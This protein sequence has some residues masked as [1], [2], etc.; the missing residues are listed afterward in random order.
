[1]TTAA[2]T[3]T[4]GSAGSSAQSTAA[5][6]TATSQQQ[7]AANMNTF[8]ELLTAQLQNQDPL[9]PMDT[10]QFTN[11]LV[12]FAQV[13]QQIDI[14]QNL[15]T[16]MGS[17]NS[18]ALAS[19]ANYIGTGVTAV[20]SSLPLQNSSA[21]FYYT[22]PSDVTSVSAVITDSAGNI[23]DTLTGST[24]AGTHSLTWNG[25]NVSGGTEPDGTY[26]VTVTA[27]GSSGS[28]TQLDTAI[29]GTVT[30][31]AVDPN[32]NQ[33]MVEIG[34]VGIDLSNIIEVQKAG[35]TDTN[36]GSIGSAINNAQNS[37]NSNSTSNTNTG[38]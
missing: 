10:S 30:G 18:A 6:Q 23:V 16:M 34:S 2:A 17:Q 38:S 36:L 4:L 24:T 19:S 5:S 28:T 37:S 9:N 8:L 1:M 20:S 21:T 14:N 26:T 31:I 11:Q 7:L 22:T 29:S 12:L 3:S 33:P 15:E 32:N 27:T 35:S 13:Q 25:A